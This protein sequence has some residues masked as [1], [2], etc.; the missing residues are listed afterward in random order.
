MPRTRA[1]CTAGMGGVLALLER[2]R[3][4][5]AGYVIHKGGYAQR[6]YRLERPAEHLP[7]G[8]AIGQAES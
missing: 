7:V 8:S 2:E 1:R 3:E 4:W 6:P 5:Q